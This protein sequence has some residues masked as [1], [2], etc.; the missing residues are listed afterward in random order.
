MSGKTPYSIAIKVKTAYISDESDPE[1]NRY[2]FVYTIRLRNEGG[3]GAK[4]VSR[5]WTISNADGN[6][7][8]VHGTGVVGE[9]PHL[10]PGEE[11]EYTSGTILETPIGSM[12]GY[13]QFMADDGTAFEAEIPVF[14]LSHPHMIH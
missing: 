3:V 4:L 14:T 7:Q 13:Y 2:A 8:Q 6:E 10:K 1:S 11:Y 12:R 9:Q 5:H